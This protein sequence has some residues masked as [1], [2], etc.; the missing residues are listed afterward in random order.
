MPQTPLNRIR[1]ISDAESNEKFGL[2]P[3]KRKGPQGAMTRQT[4]HEMVQCEGGDSTR[5]RQKAGERLHLRRESG[6]TLARMLTFG[7]MHALHR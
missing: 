6:R 5:Q 2:V 4:R 3:G 7:C 1:N